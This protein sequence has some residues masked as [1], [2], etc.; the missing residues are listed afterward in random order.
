MTTDGNPRRVVVFGATSAIAQATL[1]VLVTRGA[2]VYCVGRNRT[3]LESVL[4]DLRVRG[5]ADRVVA[6]TDADL[7]DTARHADLYRAAEKTLGPVDGVLIAHGDLP[8]Q[9]QCEASA[10]AAHRA[11][12]L[13][14]LSVVSLLIHAAN[15]LEPRGHGVIATITSVAGDRGR[16]SN[17]VYG[18]AKRLV[19]TFLEGLRLRL[20][21]RGV[22]VVD[23]KPG[24]VRTPM[25]AH[26]PQD[27]MLWSEPAKVGVDI[28][29]ALAGRRGAVYVPA[30]WFWIMLVVRHIP[31]GLFARLR[32]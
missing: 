25:T 28:A 8:D 17:Y 1:R 12:T 29:D 18:S 4:A 7:L 3:R 32:L 24:F 15:L 5:G 30:Y 21:P 9:A 11:L 27:S 22:R 2:N 16:R 23:V 14:A 20:E 6:G 31:H 19:S 13:N 10:A 26:L